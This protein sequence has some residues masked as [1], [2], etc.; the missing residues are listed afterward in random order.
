[1]SKSDGNCLCNGTGPSTINNV[2]IYA[3][4]KC[5]CTANAVSVYENVNDSS[6]IE[7]FK[8][9]N[10]FIENIIFTEKENKTFID[11]DEYENLNDSDKE[12]AKKLIIQPNNIDI[13]N[14]TNENSSVCL[15]K[16]T[17]IRVD[18][19][20]KIIR[21]ASGYEYAKITTNDK[22]TYYLPSCVAKKEESSPKEVYVSNNSFVW[23]LSIFSILLTIAFVLIGLA[24]CRIR[25]NDKKLKKLEENKKSKDKASSE[26]EF[27]IDSR[28]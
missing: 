24:M 10:F 12:K 25:K 14:V 27:G 20:K 1:M 6:Y 5:N 22:K 4:K 26:T 11:L 28:I 18:L 19:I 3:R 9:I 7:N 16:Y 21:C 2:D 8:P 23:S 15:V 17:N 13:A